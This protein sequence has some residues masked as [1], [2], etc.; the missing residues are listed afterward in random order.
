MNLFRKTALIA[1]AAMMTNAISYANTT[2]NS[3]LNHA[4]NNEMVFD[5]GE[6]DPVI[7][8]EADEKVDCDNDNSIV[9]VPIDSDFTLDVNLTVNYSGANISP[10]V[11]QI[12]Q[13]VN[14]HRVD[15]TLQTAN[16]GFDTFE[17]SNSSHNDLNSYGFV[18]GSADLH[19][20]V[21][22]TKPDGSAGH[23]FKILSIRIGCPSETRSRMTQ[24]DLIEIENI[25][26]PN[27]FENE[28]RLDLNGNAYEEFN[29]SLYDTQGRLVKQST[30]NYN[31]Q[32]NYTGQ[33]H[34]NELPSGIY[35]L[36]SEGQNSH[37]S[38]RVIKL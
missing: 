20:N 31:S 32:G 25:V 21:D 8:D 7:V 12:S 5:T 27:P 9:S 18:T 14:G 1:M 30:A 35:I 10:G 34:T 33:W 23:A 38:Q 24:S 2:N 15:A 16:V 6:G 17:A 4:V 13:M 37:Y 36:R 28:L 29:I 22:Y 19:V 26:M 3:Y 11:I